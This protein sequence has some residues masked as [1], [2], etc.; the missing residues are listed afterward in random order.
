M[1]EGLSR[2]ALLRRGAVL[3]GAA[4][5]AGT[6]VGGCRAEGGTPP[7]GGALAA[8]TGTRLPFHGPH[9]AGI[10]TPVP[11]AGVV[12]VFDVVAG[13]RAALVTSLQDLTTVA[14][15][16]AEGEVDAPLDALKPPPDNLIL[17]PTPQA[18]APDD[19]RRVRCL[20][21]RR[22]LRLGRPAPDP[23]GR[24]ADL[25][26]RPAGVRA[27]P[28]RPRRADLRRH[29][30][31]LHPRAAPADAGHPRLDG[32]ALDGARVQPAEHP[33]PRPH[34]DAQPAGLQGRH[35]Q[36]RPDRRPR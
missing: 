26:Q 34:L 19:H 32:R 24:D 3:G 17:G 10:V 15:R 30:R 33:R 13:D 4:V 12:A 8:P 9:Q 1:T 31:D 6:V 35:R 16:L 11:A 21:V 22:P 25:P 7:A 23:S 29:Q 2:R 20:H 14:R 36:P 18:D 28:R 27:Q 5:A